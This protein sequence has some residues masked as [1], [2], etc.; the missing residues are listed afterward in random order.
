MYLFSRNVSGQKLNIISCCN[1]I[2]I[3]ICVGQ[4]FSNKN[5]IRQTDMCRQD[6][7]MLCRKCLYISNKVSIYNIKKQKTSYNLSV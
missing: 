4:Y 2:E 7:R 1:M 3:M 5:P 6:T